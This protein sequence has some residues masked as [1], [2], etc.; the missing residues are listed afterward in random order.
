M[1]MHDA[2]LLTPDQMYA[3]D[4]LTIEGGITGAELMENAGGAITDEI[5]KRWPE[6]GRAVILCGPGNNGGDGFVVARQLKQKGWTCDV[7]LLGELSRLKGDAK[8]AAQRWDGEVKPL[9]ELDGRSA[10]LVVDGLFG[11]GLSRGLEGSVADAAKHI[12]DQGLPVVAVDIPSGVDGASGRVATTAFKADLTVTFFR[13]KPGHLLYPGRAHCGDTVVAQIGISPKVLEEIAPMGAENTPSLLRPAFP[14]LSAEGHKYHRGHT[15]S[16]SGPAQSTG[17]AR[18]A[19]MAALRVGSGLVTVVSPRD[20]MATNAAHLTAIMLRQADTGDDLSGLFSDPRFTSMIIGPALGLDD[21]AREKV[22]A[23]LS[24]APAGVLDADAL[25][26]FS[27]DPSQL[28]DAIS[29]RSERQVILTPHSGEFARLFG[30][31]RVKA[32]GKAA[33]AVAAAKLSASVVIYKGADSVIAAPDGRFAINS[34]APPTLATAGSGD[35]LAGIAAGLLAQGMHSYEAACAAVWLHGAA[36]TAFGPGLI[37][38]DLADLLPSALRD[39][40]AT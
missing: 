37:A 11:A 10:T 39:L 5:V 38:E 18:L 9:T 13:R 32:E 27:D 24:A 34:N 12:S 35:V 14:D 8:Q 21:A 23:A 6:P 30:K 22:L 1:M 28:F 3:A 29:K 4:R 25:S 40:E 20:A 36:A 17:A 16:V 19:A 33:A 31:D 15:I 2:Q 26:C 7:Y